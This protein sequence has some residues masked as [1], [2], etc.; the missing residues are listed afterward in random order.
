MAQSVASKSSLVLI[1][2][3]ERGGGRNLHHAVTT[4]DIRCGVSAKP[5]ARVAA[6]GSDADEGSLTCE[7]ST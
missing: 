3:G 1:A 6:T 7:R 2:C 4:V 5:V